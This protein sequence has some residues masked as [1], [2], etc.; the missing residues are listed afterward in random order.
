MTIIRK[1]KKLE[2]SEINFIAGGSGSKCYCA[3]TGVSASENIAVFKDAPLNSNARNCKATC[4]SPGL[5]AVLWIYILDEDARGIP[6]QG[7]CENYIAQGNVSPEI[8]N[9]VLNSMRNNYFGI[10]Q[11]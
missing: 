7:L 5:S 4:C 3:W 8:L 9:S 2:A 10:S 1:F 6:E 11:N